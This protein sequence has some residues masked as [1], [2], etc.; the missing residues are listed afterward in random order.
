MAKPVPVKLQNF[1]S[2]VKASSDFFSKKLH[3]AQGRIR[4]EKFP[5]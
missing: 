4:I 3:P 5:A 1:I 2:M